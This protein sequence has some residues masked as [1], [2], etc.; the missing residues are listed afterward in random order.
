MMEDWE[1]VIG[2]EVHVQLLT[3]S[4]MFSA[5]STAFGAEPNTQACGLD[6]GLP[7]TLPVANAE[8]IRMA[9]RFGLAI[10]ARI[11]TRNQFVRKN[12]F[13]P[14]L[15][16]GYQISQLELPIVQNG[17]LMIRDAKEGE[18]RIGIDRAHLEEDAGKSLHGDFHGMSGIDFNR[19]GTPLMEI[20]SKPDLAS[21]AE[22]VEYLKTINRLVRYLEISD[23]D[24]SQGSMRCDANISVRKKGDA[25]LGT[26]SE[27][28]NVNSFR[29]VEK[30]IDYEARR[31]IALLQQGQKVAQETRLYDSERAETRSMRSKEEA[32]DY[33]Y[34]PEPDLLPIELSAEF[35][36]DI[37][38]NMVELPAAKRAR[39]VEDYGLRAHEAD[40]LVQDR[41]L[42]DYY[43]A[44]TNRC[45][46]PAL[47]ASWVITELLGALN[48][49]G[50]AITASPLTAARLG[51]LLKRIADQT[52]SGKMGKELFQELWRQ[53]SDKEAKDAAPNVDEIIKNKGLTQ[54]TDNDAIDKIIRAVLD[55][56]PKQIEQ[57]LAGK[58]KLFGYFVG[59]V[60]Q[61]SRGRAAPQQVNT[62]L[63]LALEKLSKKGE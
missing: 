11:N 63:R 27:V 43:E 23:G 56:S 36:R 17:A 2:L 28:K 31:Q 41:T 55:D 14:D 61:R 34:F 6:V 35:V 26:R 58:D 30:A 21:A 40:I 13:Y 51:D 52:I 15:P 54:L 33:R 25:R 48:K 8:A 37:Q 53:G 4:K 57:Y 20:V 42:A 9:V 3:K 16:K 22:A 24:M 7:G 1:T 60:M 32:H 47:A 19:A 38:E 44:V 5:A 49:Q 46:K 62:Q 45:A 10:D 39:F 59:Q 18:K 50:I 29:F 12:Y